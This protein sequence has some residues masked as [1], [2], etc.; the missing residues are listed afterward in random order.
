M[1]WI[2]WS[3]EEFHKC[4]KEKARILNDQIVEY[5]SYYDLSYY[6]EYAKSN[7]QK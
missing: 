5:Q 3:K 7:K 1:Q 4:I 6:E 2:C